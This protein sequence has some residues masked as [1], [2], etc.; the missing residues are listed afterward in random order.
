MSRAPPPVSIWRL[1]VTR[2]RMARTRA[3]EHG[4][5]S[6]KWLPL[7]ACSS[8][9]HLSYAVGVLARGEHRARPV[10]PSARICAIR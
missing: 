9:F 4:D 2:M 6:T 10:G 7:R 3:G 8:H 1:G 5:W